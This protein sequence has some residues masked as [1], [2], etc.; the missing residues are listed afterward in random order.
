[1]KKKKL[2]IF[3]PSIEGGGVEKNLFI[4]SNYLA[5]K[6]NE[7]TLITASKEFNNKFKKIK[8]INPKFNGFKNRRIRY[9]MCIFE[10]IKLLLTKKKIVLFSF[11]ANLYCIIVC[12]IFR[13][14]I[15][16]R[17]NSSPSGWSQ[18][19][20][21]NFIFNKL[22]KLADRIIVNSFDFKKELKK[23]FK[24]N[25]VCIYNPLN[26]KEIIKKSKNITKLN[27]FDNLK[28]NTLK[29]LTIGRIVDQKDQITFLKA[30][31][32]LKLHSNVKLK[33]LIIGR[34]N[35]RQLLDNYIINK[36]LNSLVKIL[37][38]KSNPYPYIKK[39]DIF[40]LTS[41]FEGL[42]N[43]LL[44]SIQ[45]KKFIIST[46]CPTGPKEILN[47]NKGGLLFNIGNFKQLADKI[48]QFYIN[49]NNLKKKI[50]YAYQK[51]S[52]FDYEKN[53]KKYYYLVKKELN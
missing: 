44:E 41:K 47:G 10:L 48:N 36:K 39:A 25:S 20:I 3:M 6:I 28:K 24:V 23:K 9:L 2:V 1:M 26:K 4:I 15:I 37:N 22:L 11:Q 40:V 45:L 33:A 5:D 8:I 31:N 17:S 52:R 14:K 42:P 35:L 13:T 18:N 38:F 21:K 49:K 27:F 53:L 7:I 34:G 30:I 50:K 29:I 16:I 32:Y 12:K 51:L 43:V 46:N 19:F